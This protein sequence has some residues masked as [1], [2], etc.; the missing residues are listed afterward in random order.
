[1]TKS[2]YLREGCKAFSFFVPRRIG[3]FG[4][5]RM[6][7][8]KY[9]SALLLAAGILLQPQ[10]AISGAQS[11]MRSWA[12]SVAPALFPFLA[13]MPVLT[14]A[15]ACAAYERIFSYPMRKLFALPGSAAPAVIIG[16]ISGSPGGAAAVTRIAAQTN[17]PASASKR[18]ALAVCAVS[19]CYLVLGV[20]QGLYGNAK[21]GVQM[22]AIQ[23][24][25]QLGLL[26]LLRPLC[27]GMQG[28]VPQVNPR[29]DSQ[30]I[31][32]A[33]EIMLTVC[34]Y[35]VFFSVIAA[36]AARFT[37][38]E[39]GKLLLLALDLPSAMP[40]LAQW[41]IPGKLLLQEMAVGFG[42]I[43][44][45]AQN[46]NVL[47]EIGVSAVEYISVRLLAGVISAAL[48]NL[49]VFPGK[50]AMNTTFTSKIYAFSLLFA[51]IS[52]LPALILFSKNIFL[53]KTRAGKVPL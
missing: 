4:G 8:I 7:R 53:N 9:L 25:V 36:V 20:G 23:V 31:R 18:I 49:L 33:V 43:C 2:V 27:E 30:P 48:S 44:I 17:M 10:A 11:A 28:P 42:G 29:Q 50:T 21:L 46:L 13:L 15:E 45:A 38:E 3:L 6:K 32:S 47:R 41:E 22:A 1:M 51:A 19:P 37:G 52:T 12:Y 16:M 26:L 39:A 40:Q 35:M 14:G 24:S 34:G 5:E